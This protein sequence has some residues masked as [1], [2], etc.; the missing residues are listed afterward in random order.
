[1]RADDQYLFAREVVF[2]PLPFD[3]S[4][5]LEHIFRFWEEKAAHG[6]PSEQIHAKAVLSEVAEFPVLRDK[7]TTWILSKCIVIK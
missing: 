3:I 1:M 4:L 2:P 6:S 7:S 5:S